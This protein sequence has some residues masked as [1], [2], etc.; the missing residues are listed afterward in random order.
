MGSRARAAVPRRSLKWESISE[1]T[2]EHGGAAEG[3]VAKG[4]LKENVCSS[5][6]CILSQHLPYSPHIVSE[7]LTSG[8]FL[9]RWEP[10]QSPQTWRL[11]VDDETEMQ[12]C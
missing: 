6:F 7:R 8:G 5:F 11:H 9:V 1:G 4:R 12:R 10:E 2:G 3:A